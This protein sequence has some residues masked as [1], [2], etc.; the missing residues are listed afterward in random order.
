MH[1]ISTYKHKKYKIP[2]ALPGIHMNAH[3]QQECYPMVYRHCVMKGL[4]VLNN[5]SM[6][7]ASKVITLKVY[8]G[9]DAFIWHTLWFAVSKIYLSCQKSFRSANE[10]SKNKMNAFKVITFSPKCC[11]AIFVGRK[12][13]ACCWPVFRKNLY[14]K[15]WTHYKKVPATPK[16][17]LD[18]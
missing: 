5:L 18:G 9:V 13:Q 14:I 10:S 12:L 2:Q 6:A 4:A 7:N 17:T 11:T 8:F 3:V 15:V 1:N 16:V